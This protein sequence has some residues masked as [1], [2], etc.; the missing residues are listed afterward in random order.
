ISG[1]ASTG[2]GSLGIIELSQLKGAVDIPHIIITP[3]KISVTSLFSRKYFIILFNILIHF[4]VENCHIRH[5]YPSN[6]ERK[7]SISK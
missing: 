6:L 2:T 1:I 3:S 7:K 5:N 4:D